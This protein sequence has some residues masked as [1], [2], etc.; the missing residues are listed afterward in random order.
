MAGMQTL[1]D[2]R[3]NAKAESPIT[4]DLERRQ[5]IGIVL[6]LVVLTPLFL[7]ASALML[8]LTFQDPSN[9]AGESSGS[10][11]P[12]ESLAAGLIG[13]L[14]AMLMVGSAVGMIVRRRRAWK[15]HRAA[16]ELGQK[17]GWH[18][19]LE[20]PTGG[21]RG[22]LF[23]QGEKGI[24]EDTLHI[25]EPRFAEV[26]NFAFLSETR[27]NQRLEFGYVALEMPRSLP[28]M[29]LASE[30]KQDKSRAYDIPFTSD[31]KLS[32]EGDF[33]R[34]FTLYCPRDYERD[35]LY[36]F[37]PD[38]M[39]MMIDRAA[40]FDIE[41]VDRWLFVI[42]R[43]PFDM[44]NEDI[45]RLTQTLNQT[46]GDLTE[47]QVSRY[48]DDRT[49]DPWRVGAAGMRLRDRRFLTRALL[50][51]GGAWAIGV[52][53]AVAYANAVGVLDQLPW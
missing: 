12:V 1:E 39:A 34:S 46:I 6:I 27:K 31:Q 50:I 24:L 14:L 8:S 16:A 44:T 38:L 19:Q 2:F 53:V 17:F 48:V 23:R 9:I 15:R 11:S 20:Q 5:N 37:T 49:G 45:L 28:H 43:E 4:K 41:I 25:H 35:A 26:G 36:V 33:D 42:A 21:F 22:T 40:G 18:Y 13:S 7:L 29:Y 51:G 30:Q 10:L 32:L 47:R 3:P 52:G